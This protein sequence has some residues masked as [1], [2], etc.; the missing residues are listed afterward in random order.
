MFGLSMDLSTC[1]G[2]LSL[3]YKSK[4]VQIDTRW[5]K[6]NSCMHVKKKRIKN[7]LSFSWHGYRKVLRQM[8]VSRSTGWTG[9]SI[10]CAVID[11]PLKLRLV[12]IDLSSLL[13][14]LQMFDGQLTF[15]NT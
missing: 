7:T 11:I 12:N 1:Y 6:N 2:F 4:L 3:D 10:S 8:G 13:L 14:H 5:V 9:S 15:D